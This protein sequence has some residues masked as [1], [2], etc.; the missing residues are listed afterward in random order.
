MK[1]IFTL[2]VLLSTLVATLRAEGIS[3]ERAENIARKVL[4]GATRSS[5]VCLVWDSSIFAQTRVE[6]SEPTFYVV[7]STLGRG[8]VVVAG[9]DAVVPVLAYSTNYYAP[10]SD[11]LPKNF[12]GWLRYVDRVVSDA[13]DR[14]L[15]ANNATAQLWSQEYTPVDAV[16]LNTARWSQVAPYNNQCPVESGAHSLTGC[17]QTAM[18][19]IMKHHRW[20]EAAKGTTEPYETI[21]G[22][23]VP[24]RDINHSYD[25]DTMLETY[26]EGEY[27]D[28]EAEAVATLMADLGYAFKANYTA[29]DTSALP[30]IEVLYNNF[31][32]SPASRMIISTNPGITYDSWVA[33]LRRE[34]ESNRPIFYVGYTAENSGHAFVLDGV[35]ANDYF[36]VNWGWN[37]LYDGFFMLDNLMLDN[38][39]FTERHWGIFGMYPMRDGEADN[40]LGLASGGIVL[41]ETDFE[42][43]KPFIVE[44]L[45][46]VNNSTFLVFDGKVR[47]GVCN[48]Q[49]EWKSWA[50]EASD[51]S[52]RSTYQDS[53]VNIEATITHDI[54]Q[55]DMLC[56]YYCSDDSEKWYRMYGS[57]DGA[58]DSVVLKYAPIGDTTSM[59]FDKESGLLIVKYDYDVKSAL[60]LLG[61]SVENGVTISR[62]RMVVDTKYLVSGAEYSIKLCREDVEDKTISFKFNKEK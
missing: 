48:A 34:I 35:D 51:V 27:N 49:G 39:H 13:R 1:R 29:V 53:K 44:S 59:S 55:G 15:K 56:A 23:A 28:V 31:G 60:S 62:G 25:W 9:D 54:E 6:L 24:Q 46:Y 61:E 33:L 38:Y 40:W 3:P 7:T 58:V 16:M 14:G 52:L 57:A 5:D 50:S 42:R 18:A 19:I 41:S 8:F 47:L 10:L 2:L 43:D 37:G 45:S 12:E 21:Y 22:L 11:N 20:P 30:D 17:T 26:V 4:G 36:H 32:Y